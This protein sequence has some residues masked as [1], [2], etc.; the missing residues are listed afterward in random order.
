MFFRV[1]LLFFR[2]FLFVVDGCT[3]CDVMLRFLYRNG[4][5]LDLEPEVSAEAG[6]LFVAFHFSEPET[7]YGQFEFTLDVEESHF[8]HYY[9]LL[10]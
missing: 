2:I 5:V 6:L 10:E 3:W 8:T 1:Y 7:I 9:V 4:D